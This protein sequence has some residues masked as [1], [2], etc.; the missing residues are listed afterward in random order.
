MA[1]NT[2]VQV[3]F[4]A[5]DKEY[6]DSM[7]QMNQETK[8]LRQE[9]KLQQEQMKLTGSDSDKL[10]AKLQNLSQ[11][12]ALAQ[13]ATQTTAEHLQRAKQLYGSNSAEVAKLEAKLRSQLITEQQ[14]SNQVKQTSESLKEAKSAEQ[15]RT[16]ETAKAS[17]KL[18]ELKGK[19]DQLQASTTKLNAQYE[20]QKA[21]LGENA[22][23]TERFR[24]AIDHLGKQHTLA[25][26]K[27]QNYQQ[28]LDQAKQKYGENSAEIQ[29]YETQL[30]QART[31]EQQLQT[32]ISSTNRSLQEQENATKQLKT[33]F[34]ATGTSVD[35]FANALGNNL[36]NA[37]RNG[38]ATA[39]QL[40][41]ALELIGREA[42]GT[43]ADVEKLKRA[44]KSVD[45]G[46]SIENVRNDIRELSREAERASLTVKELD[47]DLENMLGAAG[48]GAGISGAIEQALDTSKMQTK[49]DI[50]FDV[51]ESS[52]KSVEEA[53]RGVTAYGVDAEASLEGVRRQWALNKGVSDEA[54]AAMVKGAATISQSYSGIDFTELIQEVN[55]I[56]S[57]L[58]VTQEGALGL[59]NSLLKVGFPSE[60]LDIIAE[61]GGQLTRAG[62]SAEEVQAI[63][64]AGVE[65]GTW[66]IDNLLDGLKE[67]R[68]KAA[69]FGQG[70]DKAMKETLE[71]T[72]I[73]AGQLQ[74]WGE[75][76]ANGGREGSEAMTQIAQALSEVEDETK[77]NE[78]G[79]KLFGR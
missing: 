27:V 33:F 72:K 1:R 14:L 39:K 50:T 49:I 38:T 75:A 78:L 79:V 51:P 67:G 74:K 44:L 28:Q 23:E 55:E 62:Y 26:S 3:T 58:G 16:S 19:Q 57:E 11:Q 52:K 17:Q 68:I 42:L 64:E 63:M 45:D 54:N 15:E 61:Y 18:Q 77:R 43:E 65:T 36:T 6:K 47:I 24:L 7:K 20:L 25:A 13:K 73:S 30:L 46:N 31:A 22:S 69:E 60:Q 56:G 10:Q 4:K 34:D 48:A 35:R 37:I 2:E 41:K 12:Y 76:V 21:Q 71:G 32:Q 66:N 70:V 40:E 29:R 9:M 5:D 53:V 8:K 59:T